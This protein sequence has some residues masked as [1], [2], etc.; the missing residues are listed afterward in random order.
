MAPDLR[1][2]F[3]ADL[4][5]G[6]LT[7]AREFAAPRQLVWDCHTQ[8]ALLDKWFAPKPMTTFTKAFDFREGGRWHHAMIAPDGTDYWGLVEYLSISPIDGYRTR[9]HFSDAEGR[10]NPDLPGSVWD[11]VFHDQGDRCLVRSVITYPSSA[12]LQTV[13][14]MGMKPGM[15]STFETLDETLET[16]RERS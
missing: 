10:I 3:M 7:V 12:D 11:V 1:F 14:D 2:D 16:L 6:V 9:D 5:K 13:I 15:A 8:S 4:Q